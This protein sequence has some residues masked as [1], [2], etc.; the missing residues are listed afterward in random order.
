VLLLRSENFAFH[1]FRWISPSKSFF[2]PPTASRARVQESREWAPSRLVRFILSRFSPVLAHVPAGKPP[3]VPSL[4]EFPSNP[5]GRV[6]VL[7]RY[8]LLFFLSFFF[9]L[10]TPDQPFSCSVVLSLSLRDTWAAW[11]NPLSDSGF[12]A[13]PLST[14]CLRICRPQVP[15][16]PPVGVKNTASFLS[17]RCA[18]DRS[19]PVPQRRPNFTSRTRL[20]LFT[21]AARFFFF[22]KSPPTWKQPPFAH[23]RPLNVH[24]PA[25]PFCS[26]QSRE[27]LSLLSALPSLLSA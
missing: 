23:P 2:P 17:C 3:A 21:G 27:N 20:I 1:E 15:V 9:A 13:L 19:L 4:R 8:V 12:S 18:F 10:F 14:A 24:P 11:S 26:T 5:G 6:V 25:R 16:S 22:L 7:L